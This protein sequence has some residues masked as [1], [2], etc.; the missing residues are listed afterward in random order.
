MIK[1]GLPYLDMVRRVVE[2]YQKP[3]FAF[4]VWGEYA[5]IKAAA[6]NGWLDEDRAI[7][8]SLSV[9]KRVGTTVVITYFALQAARVLGALVR[10][11]PNVLKQIR[12]CLI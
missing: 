3:T 2:T 6:A 11:Q 1:P 9:F 10:G 5:M 8:E 7:L 4:Q 12:R